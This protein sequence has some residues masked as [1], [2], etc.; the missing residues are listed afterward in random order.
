MNATEQSIMNFCK[1]LTNLPDLYPSIFQRLE[2]VTG[3]RDYFTP[4]E[5]KFAVEGGYTLCEIAVNPFKPLMRILTDQ[6]REHY[7]NSTPSYLQTFRFLKLTMKVG[8]SLRKA[9][10][11]VIAKL[12]F[13]GT[14]N[15]IDDPKCFSIHP[16][17][18]IL[19]NESSILFRQYSKVTLT[20]LDIETAESNVIDLETKTIKHLSIHDV[21]DTEIYKIRR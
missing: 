3:T 21:N 19:V 6:L 7:S 14:G 10:D 18:R 1:K 8:T 12:Q 13:E 5:D 15:D 16:F 17:T 20:P 2:N 11:I 4:I 9:E